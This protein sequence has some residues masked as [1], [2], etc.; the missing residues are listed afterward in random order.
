M[1]NTELLSDVK[2]VVP[3]SNGEGERKVIPA[4]KFVLAISSPVF[5]AM[6]YGQTADSKDSIELPDCEYESLL[7]LFRFLYSDKANL[8][9]SNVMQVLCLA[10]KFKVPSLAQKCAEYLRDNLRASNVFGILPYARKFKD[11][12]LANR[13][14][15]L[16][17]MHTKEA[18]KSDV[19]VTVKR[20]LVKSVVKRR[21]LTVKEVDLFKAADHWA[22]K[23]LS[24]GESESKKV[25]PAHKFVLAISSPVFFAMFYGQMAETKDSIELPDCEYESLLELFRFLYSDKVNLS[26]SN[27]MQVLYLANKYMLPSLTEKCTG[28]LRGNL[29]ASNVFCILP[30]AQKFED[31]D[32]E[33][34]CWKVIEKQTQEAMTS[35][36]FLSAERSVVESVVKKEVLNVEEVELFKAV[37][38]WATKECERQGVTSYGGTKRRLLGE[39]IVKGIRFPLIPQKDFASVVFDSRILNFEEVGDMI[40]HYNG[41]LAT[42][43][44]FLQA[45]RIDS[46]TYQCCRFQTFCAPASYWN[47]TGNADCIILTVE[48]PVK[49]YGVQHFGSEGRK[50]TVTTDIIDPID[51]TSLVSRAGIYASEKSDTHGYYGFDVMFDRPVNLKANKEY[52][53]KSLIE[54]PKSWDS[55]NTKEAVTSDVFVTVERSLVKSVVKRGKLT[56]KEVDLFKAA[57]HWATNECERQGVTPDGETKRRILGEDIV[58]AIRFPLISQEEFVSAVFDSHILTLQEVGAMMK[59]Y[60]GVLKSP[61]PFKKTMRGRVLYHRSNRFQKFSSGCYYSEGDSIEFTVS[62]PIMLRGVQYFG[63]KHSKH[64]VVT[65]VKDTI[66]NSCLGKDSGTYHSKKDAW[67]NFYGFD[68]SFESA[69]CLEANKQYTLVSVFKVKREVLNAEEV[70]LFKAVDHW[71]TKECE[72]QGMISDGG[73]KRRLLVVKPA[74]LIPLSTDAADFKRFV[75]QGVNGVTMEALLTASK[76]VGIQLQQTLLIP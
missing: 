23:E 24:T 59:H 47:Y 65:E 61:L 10:N 21:K 43:L 27:V 76:A 11:K 31:K 20:S 58:K 52:K 60:C 56:V 9:G 32:L 41:V 57:D 42:P 45:C 34:R 14:W 17:E 29:K 3:G 4:H 38:R 69:L 44:P 53:L 68:V 18:V 64:T 75:R 30:Y 46:T 2:F 71:A 35:D 26:G 40:K 39:D 37:D 28:Y 19:F 12:H 49:V 48:K 74:E 1:F 54:G 16:I 70:E 50:Y 72:G 62:K 7:E 66:H 15:N 55:P 8:S 63:S 13:C 67:N 6:F 25:I 51:N 33:D 73:T 5:F 22:T 36:E